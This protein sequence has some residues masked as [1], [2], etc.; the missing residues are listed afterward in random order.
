MNT[1]GGTRWTVAAWSEVRLDS[2]LSVLSAAMGN[3]LP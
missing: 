2:D 1:V 3:F